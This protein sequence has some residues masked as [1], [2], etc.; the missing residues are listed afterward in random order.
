[1]DDFSA[2]TEHPG[3]SE[4]LIG[5][6]CGPHWHSG[7]LWSALFLKRMTK[8]DG[9]EKRE[10][11]GGRLLL[12]LAVYDGGLKTNTIRVFIFE[13]LEAMLIAVVRDDPRKI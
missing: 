3:G 4:D 7:T 6:E 9:V 2:G 13:Y 11:G 5:N 1:M 8:K 10:R 12:H